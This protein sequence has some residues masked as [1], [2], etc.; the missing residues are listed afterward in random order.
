MSFKNKLTSA[1]IQLLALNKMKMNDIHFDIGDRNSFLCDFYG[2]CEDMWVGQLTNFILHTNENINVLEEKGIVEKSKDLYFFDEDEYEQKVE[3]DI[4]N[5]VPI[6]CFNGYVI[7][8]DEFQVSHNYN[9]KKEIVEK[10]EKIVA[11]LE[12]EDKLIP[13]F[14]VKDEKNTEFFIP[15]YIATLFDV[16]DK[17]THFEQVEESFVEDA[18]LSAHYGLEKQDVEDYVIEKLKSVNKI[19]SVVNFSI[20]HQKSQEPI[21]WKK[22]IDIK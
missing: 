14:S 5:G 18:L 8:T 3:V 7:D 20:S 11:Q 2:N 12:F 13:I 17:L 16:L 4:E 9:I 19:D 21:C 10:A 6:Y 15:V 22:T 1:I